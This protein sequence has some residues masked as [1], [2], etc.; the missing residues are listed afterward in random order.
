M[1]YPW[2]GS[3]KVILGIA[4]FAIGALIFASREA[5]QSAI[6]S[7]MTVLSPGFLLV[8][9]LESVALRWMHPIIVGVIWGLSSQ[10]YLNSYFGG[11]DLSVHLLPSFHDG[12]L[13]VLL[14]GV[15]LFSA[16]NVVYG[17][18]SSMRPEQ[19]K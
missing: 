16:L 2:K 14:T 3:L 18:M 12:L 4:L 6:A 19:E 15:F 13:I 9:L 5:S 17:L 7:A 8:A 10:Y 11:L 1:L